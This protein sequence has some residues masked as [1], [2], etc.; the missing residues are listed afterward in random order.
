MLTTRREG[1]FG[2]G[3]RRKCEPALFDRSSDEHISGF[4]MHRCAVEFSVAVSSRGSGRWWVVPFTRRRGGSVGR[5]V[6]VRVDSLEGVNYEAGNHCASNW[7]SVDGRKP[8]NVW[9]V[10]LV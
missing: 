4:V 10:D 9:G 6:V 1:V 7:I 3:L 8:S 5:S 2:G